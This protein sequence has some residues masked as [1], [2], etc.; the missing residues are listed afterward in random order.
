M[1]EKTFDGLIV[2]KNAEFARTPLP[3]INVAKDRIKTEC[4]VDHVF[5]I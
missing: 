4:Y 5:E 2:E 3:I 1:M